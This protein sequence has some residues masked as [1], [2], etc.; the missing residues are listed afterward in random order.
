MTIIPL[1]LQVI[2]AFGILNV[3]LL[4]SG[5]A[6][7]YRG[8]K[9]RNLR[10]EFA[11]YGLPFPVMCLVGGIKVGLAVAL[12]VGIWI[13]ALVQPAAIGMGGMML[14][15]FA[16]HLKVRDPLVKSLPALGVLAMCVGIIFL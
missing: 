9:A 6:T 2:V 16:M 13:P 5:S 8:A 1:I 15:A 11:T 4:R 3:W 10:E 14:G 7:P 12:L